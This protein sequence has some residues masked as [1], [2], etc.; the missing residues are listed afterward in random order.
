MST[1]VGDEGGF[2]PS[3][4]ERRGRGRARGEAIEAAGYRP[5][6]HVVVALDPAGERAVDGDGATRSPTRAAALTTAE[7]IDLWEHW[8]DRYPIVTIEDGLAEDD[9]DGWRS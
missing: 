7:M 9:W 3:L 5:G 4:A 2:A 8:V 1:D 6:E